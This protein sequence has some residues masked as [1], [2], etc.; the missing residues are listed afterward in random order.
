MN[1]NHIKRNFKSACFIKY[2]NSILETTYFDVQIMFLKCL[3]DIFYL[4]ETYSIMFDSFYILNYSYR[5][6]FTDYSSLYIDGTLIFN[7]CS[8]LLKVRYIVLCVSHQNTYNY[9]VLTTTTILITF[10][11]KS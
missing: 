10:G 5:H 11:D 6:F 4:P 1:L 9:S 7:T 3:C 8:C 2:V